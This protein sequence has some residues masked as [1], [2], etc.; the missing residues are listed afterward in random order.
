MIKVNTCHIT[1]EPLFLKGSEKADFLG[2]DEPVANAPEMTPASDVFYDLTATKTGQDLLVSGRVYFELDTVCARCMNPTRVTIAN[3]K[4]CLFYEKVPEQ[5][6]DITNDIREELLLNMPDYIH[7]SED[8]KG[9][10]S[11][12]GADLNEGPCGCENKAD[13]LPPENNP[14]NALDQL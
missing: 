4:L 6:V 11:G 14:W 7:C 2:F 1:D 13:E 5:E 10:C 12:C 8:C 3:E 9:R